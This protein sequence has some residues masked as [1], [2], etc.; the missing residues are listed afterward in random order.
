MAVTKQ[1]KPELAV[2]DTIPSGFTT[3]RG[4][5]SMGWQDSFEFLYRRHFWYITEHEKVIAV[6]DNYQA[7]REDFNSR[8]EE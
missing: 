7:A 8:V 3:V 6:H 1:R 2:G 4:A 5:A